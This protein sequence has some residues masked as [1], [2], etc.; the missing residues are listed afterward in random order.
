MVRGNGIQ[1]GAY[2]TAR[3]E[4]LTLQ[5]HLQKGGLKCVFSSGRV[6]QISTEVVEQLVLIAMHQ[7]VER[8]TVPRD[9]ICREQRFV[10]AL[11]RRGVQLLR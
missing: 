2:L 10:A 7:L 11:P 9:L 8:S 1:P 4:L 6:P 3:L 5:M